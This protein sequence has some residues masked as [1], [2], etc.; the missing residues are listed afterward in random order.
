LPRSTGFP[1]PADRNQRCPPSCHRFDRQL[2]VGDRTHG[3]AEP[4]FCSCVEV[5]TSG[6][7]SRSETPYVGP[8]QNY[9]RAEDIILPLA[10][11][12]VTPDMLLVFIEHFPKD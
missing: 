2:D 12:G 8:H 11:D 1:V 7:L 6:E 4:D 10:R 5:A 9:V 3:A